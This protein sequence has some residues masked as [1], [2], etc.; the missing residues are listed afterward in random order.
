[1][2][3]SQ[4]RKL[5]R[6]MAADGTLIFDTKLNNSQLKK[7]TSEIK[8]ETDE[9]KKAA[10]KA[11]QGVAQESAKTTAKV[12][13]EAG[14]ITQEAGKASKKV[15]TDAAKAA[16]EVVKESG[17]TSKQAKDDA[18]KVS[19]DSEKTSK[20]I[21]KDADKVAK[22]SKETSKKT[23]KD[24]DETSKKT[25]KDS[26][27]TS[28]KTQKDSEKTKKSHEKNSK[29]SQTAWE[30]A[31][32]GIANASGMIAKASAAAI[33]AGAGA[34]T[35]G[36][37]AA[38]AVGS[39]FEASM[40]QVAAT[41]GIT[42]QEIANGSD[43]F[44]KL[45]AAAKEAGA[46]TMFSASQA[47]EALNYMAL[48]GYTA[49]EAIATM[50][51]VLNLA[52][53]GGMELS[54]ASDMVTDSMSALGDKAGTVESFVD[55]MAKTSQKSNTSVEQLGQAILTVGGT[56]KSLSGGVNEM[57]TEL[58]ILADSGIKGAEGGTLLRNV[59]L[60]LSA[61]TDVAAKAMNSLKL[62]VLDSEGKMRPLNDTFNDLNTIL[63]TMTEGE[64]TKVLSTIFNAA[65]LK[66]VNALLA[67]S[68]ERF[69]E[70]NGYISDCDGAAAA[71]AETM[72]D[73]LQGK[74]TLLKSALEGLGIQIYE[75][76]S[77]Q[78]KD[79]ASLGNDYIGMLAQG[80]QEGGVDGLIDALG[81]ILGDM[82]SRAVEMAPQMVELA[83][84]LVH[85]L[86]SG[87]QENSSAII[88]GLAQILVIA[89]D[90]AA[91]IIPDLTAF[92][93]Q[94]LVSL[95]S[96]LI[97][98]APIIMESLFTAIS[99]AVDSISDTFPVL[100]PLADLLSTLA[101]NMNVVS[102]VTLGL[103][104]AFVA[105]KSA[106][107]IASLIK[108][109]TIATQGMTLAQVAAKAAQHLLNMAMLACP[110][111]WL[112]LLIVFVVALIAGLVAAFIY[113][114]NTSEG[115]R[116]FWINLWE[117]VKQVLTDAWNA[118]VAFF[119]ETIPQ[120]VLNIVEWFSELPDKIG[121]V[122]DNVVQWFSELPEK[123]AYHLGYTV[124]KTVLWA[125]QMRAK[126]IEAGKNFLDGVINFLKE[127]PGRVWNWFVSTVAKAAA[128]VVNM[129]LK[130]NEAGKQFL[131]KVIE[132]IKNLPSRVWT[133]LTNTITKVIAFAAD[134][135]DKAKEAGKNFFNGIVDELM[136]LPGKM[137]EIAGNI[138]GGLVK[139]I[140]DGMSSVSNAIKNLANSA[141]DGAENALGIHSP[142]RKFRWVGEMC[143]EGFDQPLEDYN[144]YA[145]LN[146]SMQMGSGVMRMNYDA[147]VSS[148]GKELFIDYA[149]MG[150][151][152]LR[153]F[154]SAGLT[155][156]IGNR[157]FGRLVSEVG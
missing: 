63:S 22:K 90:G 145:T 51:T 16:Q 36:A 117:T 92:A 110:L 60:A 96:A 73:N 85:S 154:K 153:A 139:G 136:A 77:D 30:R 8:K 24:S 27:E 87:L 38:I 7:G 28:K 140:T 127:L 84:A 26:D 125:V 15:S 99:N 97:E 133:W 47:A 6:F 43:D 120:L 79:A 31:F 9:V 78:L 21:E 52:A 33:S 130:A 54:T 35:A 131:E 157:E 72:S 156:K 137:G 98:N 53:A 59:I 74:I 64:Q 146:R 41:M 44:D 10:E 100:E 61:P 114:W 23:Q 129:R 58:G 20:K 49:D 13:G 134:M 45:K 29:D 105:F 14:K 66:G 151:E 144:P 101:D 155:V 103:T 81:T 67:N 37:G 46:S 25:Q 119:T 148:A 55:K 39:N 4:K 152:M 112:G 48:A 122:I 57:N 17:K 86:V 80:M 82:V 68:G 113:F 95:G 42:V 12:K 121:E 109:V 11:A 70:L 149:L 5:V 138:I 116:E 143:V 1:M 135:R 18:D 89:V 88:D 118:I 19:K 111:T 76:M 123:I 147:T 115:F 93:V 69:D 104:T 75:G 3:Q 132:F 141:I 142:S 107:A 2:S 71:M 102:G 106:L 91:G 150:K 65:D 62:E 94:L 124:T 34:I 128:F 83:V 108:A 56:A 126:A 40:S 50:P 32:K